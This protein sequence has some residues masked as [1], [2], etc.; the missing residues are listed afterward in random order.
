MLN[1]KYYVVQDG[2]IVTPDIKTIFSESLNPKDVAVNQ[3]A[4]Q[5]SFVGYVI[6]NENILISFPKHT[7]TNEEIIHLQKDHLKLTNYSKLLFKCIKKTID[8]QNDKYVGI[9]HELN[10]DYPFMAFLN[11][12]QYYQKFGLFTNEK[13]VK[14]FGF[15]GRISWKDTIA[16]SPII[17]NDNNLLYLPVVV[18]E[19]VDQLEFI[20]K[21]MA[22]VIDSTLDRFSILLEGNK[23]NINVSDIDFSNKRFV[24]SQ[25]KKAK[26]LLFKNI[27][28]QLVDSLISFFEQIDLKG[29]DIQLKIYSFHLVWESMVGE[30]LRNK[31]V[32]VNDAYEFV[33][34]EKAEH[35]AFEKKAAYPDIR[36][37]DGFRIEPDY[38]LVSDHIRYIFDAKYYQSL[39]E[40]DYKQVAYYFLLKHFEAPRDSDGAVIRELQTY[41]ALILPT[42]K[43]SYSHTHFELNPDFN[44]DET[45]FVIIAQYLHTLTVMNNYAQ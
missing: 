16:K 38:Y 7:F 14:K 4:E 5:Y 21:C 17:V 42:E 37:K 45:K 18:R 26:R 28:Q 30:F 25:L 20:S 3:A 34:S 1:K 6:K 29:G 9:K 23:T 12:Y 36:G 39:N 19:N 10:S 2:D 24:I 44:R 43:E 33:F 35:K 32:K 11:V 22:H 8:K 41:N 40:L 27:Q 31:F 15:A 13:E